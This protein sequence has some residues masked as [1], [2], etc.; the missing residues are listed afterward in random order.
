MREADDHWRRVKMRMCDESAGLRQMGAVLMNLKEK[1]AKT[2][3]KEM[4]TLSRLHS[5]KFTPLILKMYFAKFPR[6][7]M[8]PL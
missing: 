1:R 7:E 6:I 4:K 5:F 2:L 3:R 8:G